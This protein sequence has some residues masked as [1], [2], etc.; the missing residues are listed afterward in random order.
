MGEQNRSYDN[1]A[2][3]RPKSVNEF[4][5][6]NHSFI[7]PS[8]QRGYRW[9]KKEVTDLLEDIYRFSKDSA[10]GE[11][12]YYLQPIVVKKEGDKWVV[13]DGQQRLTTILILLSFLQ[14]HSVSY[15]VTSKEL[16]SICYATRNKDANFDFFNP[17]CENDI[18]SFYIAMA[19]KNIEDWFKKNNADEGLFNSVLF[20]DDYRTVKFIWYVVEEEEEL[21]AIKLFNNL[22]K[23]KIRLTNS[24]L[25]KALFILDAE[26]R[27]KREVGSKE[28]TEKYNEVRS[29]NTDELI[30][31]WNEIENSFQNDSFWFFLANESYK[32]STRIDIL[33]DFF[34]EN[35][36]KQDQDYSYRKFQ[37]LF[38]NYN[39]SPEKQRLDEIW[40]KLSVNNFVFAW[41]QVLRVYHTFLYWYED[42]IMYHY[43]GFLVAN[44]V[45]LT[46]IY[47][48][49]NDLS[50]EAAIKALRK[51]IR[52]IVFRNITMEKI[53]SYTYSDNYKEC[54]KI[55]L[56]FNI[57]TC[58]SQYQAQVE[59]EKGNQSFRF[60]FNLFKKYKWDL[61]HVSSQTV[62][63]L[64]KPEDRKIWLSYLPA[65][66]FQFDNE[67]QKTD[68]GKCIDEAK[69]LIE[70]VEQNSYEKEFIDLYGR[71][72]NLVPESSS[73]KDD[74]LRNLTLLD[75]QTNRGYGNAL[76]P[77][78]R[79][80]II[81]NE[82]KGVFI[83]PC[84]KSMFLKYY[85]KDNESNSQWKNTWTRED[86]ECYF[87]VIKK[88][89]KKILGETL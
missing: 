88:Y 65:I 48:N 22:N 85:T 64:K 27:E 67:Q 73:M 75:C 53:D 59:K 44:G 79:M 37:N 68:W 6:G 89:M 82:K 12:E 61:E 40:K 28:K 35:N 5:D 83:P 74:T 34:T 33:F 71:I 70:K 3:F 63:Q 36:G 4:L 52:T 17:H 57:E 47:K 76:F 29:F 7:I 31:Q 30:Y 24:E 45:G 2:I 20:H 54:R 81:E 46:T 16:Y 58:V 51:L 18:D 14:K 87:D 56:F 49:C 38:D 32:P 21:E 66:H 11:K 43:I 60:P 41:Q 39:L 15:A 84:T 8:F 69:I 77:T 1:N 55:L 86:G 78:K 9:S 25:I 26:R 13:L 62:N 19:K 42:Y 50:K 23:G 72:M 80:T 10:T